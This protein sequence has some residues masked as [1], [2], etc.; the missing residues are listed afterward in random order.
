MDFDRPYQLPSV[1]NVQFEPVIVQIDRL[2]LV[3]EENPDAC[4]SKTTSW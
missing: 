1:S 2:D 4:D 3:L